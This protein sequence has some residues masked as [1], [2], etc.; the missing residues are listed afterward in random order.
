MEFGKEL[1][2]LDKILDRICSF[3]GGSLAITYNDEGNPMTRDLR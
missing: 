1:G 3:F 2:D